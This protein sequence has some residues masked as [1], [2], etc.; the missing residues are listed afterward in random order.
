MS[1]ARRTKLCKKVSRKLDPKTT[2]QNT[3]P[4]KET[5]SKHPITR[6]SRNNPIP[7]AHRQM[8]Y[9]S[10]QIKQ[11]NKPV[12]ASVASSLCRISLAATPIYTSLPIPTP[13]FPRIHGSIFATGATPPVF[14][15]PSNGLPRLQPACAVAWPIL[16]RRVWA[17]VLV[18]LIV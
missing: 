17:G 15:V 12:V 16:V 8:L 11:T 9:I 2:Y 14:L 13:S 6:T 7:I 5:N 10:K 4:S 1:I 3:K 18:V